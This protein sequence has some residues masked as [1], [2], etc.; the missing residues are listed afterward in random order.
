MKPTNSELNKE[1]GRVYFSAMRAAETLATL[2]PVS[3]AKPALPWWPF[4]PRAVSWFRAM[5]ATADG[6]DSPEARTA[7]DSLRLALAWWD[8]F[9]AALDRPHPHVE[10]E[11]RGLVARLLPRPPARLTFDQMHSIAFEGDRLTPSQAAFWRYR[12]GLPNAAD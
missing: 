1:G 2:L 4:S 5:L 10:R 9:A 12:C 7:G 11:L 8:K 3:P 6:A